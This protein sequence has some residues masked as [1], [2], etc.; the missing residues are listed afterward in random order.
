MKLPSEHKILRRMLA[1]H[2][3]GAGEYAV[4]SALNRA[5]I[6]NPR[7]GRPWY[8]GTVRAIL[9]SAERRASRWSG[10]NSLPSDS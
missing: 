5:G 4:A 8:Y 7:T 6:P 2:A 9:K 10:T 3:E 1:H